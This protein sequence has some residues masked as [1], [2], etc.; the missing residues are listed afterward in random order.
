MMQTPG[1]Y[2]CLNIQVLRHH[3]YWNIMNDQVLMELQQQAQHYNKC[4]KGGTGGKKDS[5]TKN[6]QTK[7]PLKSSYYFNVWQTL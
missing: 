3:R 7:N 4:S 1:I 5:L 6:K 2:R